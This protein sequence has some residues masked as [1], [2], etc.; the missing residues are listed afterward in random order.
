MD[1]KSTLNLPKT[2]FAMQAG[3]PKREPVMLEKWYEDKVYET[4]LEKN[5]GKPLYVLHDGPPYAN[6]DIHLG[7]AL[8]KTLKDFIVRYKNMSGF[9]AP[10]VPGWDTHGLPTEL[11]A[12]KKAGV[13]NSTAISDIELRKLCREFALG[14]LDEQRNSFKR[15]GGIGE[16]DNPYVTLRKEFEAKQIEI[17]SEMATKGLIYKG[18]KPVYWC[19]EC[20]TAL[21]EAEIEYAEDPCHSIY[22]KFRVTDDKGLLTPMGADLSKTYFVIWTTTTWTL[23]ANVAICVGPEF[24]YALVKSGDEYYVMATA[25]TES[26]MQA[27]GKTDYEILGTLKGSDLEYMKTAHPFIDR[28]SLVIVGDHVTLESGTGCVH[29]APGHGVEDYDVCHNHYPEIPIVVPVDSH[30]KMTEEAGQFAGLTTEEANKAI[31]QHL[32]DTGALF[33]LQK[34]IHQYPHC[35]RCKKPVLFRATEQWFCSVDAIKDQ[36]IEAIK[37]VKWIPGWGEDRISSMV[38]DRND[39]CISRQRRWGV[40][41]PI[42]YCKDCGEPLIEKDAMHAV[43]ELFRA[44]GSDAWYIKEAEEILPAGTKCKKCGCTSFTKERDIMDV[45]FDSGVTHAAVCD[46]RDYLHWPADLYLEGADQYRGWFQSSLLTAVGAFGQ[47]APFKECVTHGWTVDGE[48]KAMHKS[49]GNGVDPAD[50]FNENGADILRLWA[51]SADYHADVRCSKEI[52]KQ[53]S[54]NYLKFRNTCKFMLDNLVDFDPEKLTK[55][56]DMPVLD[57]W[58]LTKLNELIEKAEQS[59]CDYEFHIITHAVNDF[60]VNTLSSFY[61]DIVKDR[62]YCE[63]A[64]SATRRSAQT[65]LYLTLHTLSKLFAPILAFTCDEIWLAMPHTGD[66]DARNVVLNEM[67]KPFTAYALDSKTMARWEH[68]IAVRT[69]VNGALEEARAAKVIG[70]SLEADVHLTVPESDRFF[71]DESPEALADIFIVSKVEL[72]IGDALAVKVDNAAG[73]KCPRCWK[74]SLEANAE[75]LC[76]RCAEVVKHLHLTELL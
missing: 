21:A 15:L 57:R 36:A 26:A 27:A 7:T 55:P 60:C 46:T 11:K 69:V 8:N 14:Y 72:A 43:S 66:D 34:I 5:D 74:H 58:L 71:A 37:G 75:G 3:L 24:E 12:R 35:W 10:Y 70:K 40:P 13:S 48:G 59:Y 19:P 4:V 30:G 47:G 31:A 23:P 2:D 61:L 9:K 22:V 32:E 25:L 53:L 17:F 56:E 42:F 1:Y 20:E 18:L 44:E 45:W 39:W 51:A 16:W 52:F 54:Q 29:T 67:N 63:G 68:I 41:I 73:T 49:L 76:P 33:A 6:G 38:R 50:V 65:A 62:L 64:E 28:T